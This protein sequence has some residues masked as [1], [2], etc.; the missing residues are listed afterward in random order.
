MGTDKWNRVV[1][2]L[3]VFHFELGAHTL[4]Q[5]FGSPLPG[6]P[7][8]GPSA[9]R[10]FPIW[11]F[12]MNDSLAPTNRT[13]AYYYLSQVAEAMKSRTVVLPSQTRALRVACLNA[14]TEII[15]FEL[16]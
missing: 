8:S 10:I 7:T 3:G 6:P 4:I 11:G 2:R 5:V 1:L 14:T 15:S 12:S 13:V 9:I 16:A